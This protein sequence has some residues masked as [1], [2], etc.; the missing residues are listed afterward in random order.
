M[1]RLYKPV[2]LL[3]ALLFCTTI[4]SAKVVRVE[5]ESR[6]VILDGRSFGIIGPYEKLV[7][8][9]YFVFDPD[10][11]YNSRIVDLKLAPRNADGLV[12]AWANFTVLRPVN[13]T[14]GNVALLEVSN[15]GG[16]ASLRYFNRATAGGFDPTDA[17]HFGDGLLMRLG[18]TV[19]WVGWQWDVPQQ[20]GRLRLHVPAASGENGEPIVG[21]VRADWT[22]DRPTNVL[23]LAHRNHLAYPVLD[24][25]SPRVMLTERD[26]RLA[27]RR[28]V[29]RS[30][31]SF[32]RV[33]EGD[34]VD[35]RTHIF[36]RAG[37]QPGKIYELV[38]PAADPKIVGLGP[39][40]IRDMIS[41]A[42]YDPS[43]PFPVDHGVAI[44]IS[45]TGRF[46]RHYIYQGFNT[47]EEG[48]KALDGVMVHTAGAGRGSF[49]HRFAQPSRDAHRYSA[50]FY[51][52]D[53]FPFTSR[54]QTDW[55]TGRTDGLFAHQFVDENLPKIF[56][57]NTGYE[58]WGRAAALLHVSVDGQ[59]DVELYPNER[60]YHLASGQH[61]VG[62]FPPPDQSVMS[63]DSAYRGNPLNFL[64]TM[65][66][67]L[68]RM[69]EWVSDGTEPPPS[70]H[71]RLADG[72]LVPIDQ[73]AFPSIDGVEY[74]DVIHEAYRVG[75]GPRWWTEGIIDVEPPTL[76]VPF[77]S[78]VSQVDEL[79]NEVA[80]LRAIEILAPIA[81]YLPWNLRIG[82]PGGT[83][84]LT[85]FLGTYVPLPKTEAERQ[86]T[87]D[88]RPSIESL[89]D[90]K[91][92]YLREVERA[93]VSLVEQ[94]VLLEEDV[95]WVI[96]RAGDHWDWRSAH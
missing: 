27:E 56:Y 60:I 63:D 65:R 40:A 57:T 72:N 55:Q 53:I 89:Y 64:V 5:I 4:A 6:E 37:F 51:P 39:A 68:V 32:G 71:P 25:D 62:R 93:A 50:F 3:L 52:T 24:K 75:Y 19:I 79:G 1:T 85:D 30:E 44:G 14:A 80:G 20:E 48:R 58:Y 35:D 86:A 92:H 10:N 13:P 8:K 17:E 69:V 33:E 31:W 95:V 74:P 38:Y 88:P 45:Q 29:P 82:Y 28:I 7:G 78:L 23:D 15:R 2:A 76:G 59:R 54:T 21:V 83:D 66:A 47:D 67:L 36:M 61:F 34:V 81:T 84:E 41:Y 77:P 96:R 91:E 9:V 18:L 49:N 43:S 87:N 70:A 46:L 11:P 12:E 73:V 42:K 22:V 26:G 94:G 90:S 16:K